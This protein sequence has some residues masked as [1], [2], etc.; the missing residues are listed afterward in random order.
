MRNS[1]HR[2]NQL[3]RSPANGPM[4]RGLW[5]NSVPAIRYLR[6]S[7]VLALCQL[8][9]AGCQPTLPSTSSDLRALRAPFIARGTVGSC[10]NQCW[11]KT[12]PI[13]R[14]D[15]GLDPDATGKYDPGRVA[16]LVRSA[17]S[18]GVSSGGEIRPVSLD[19]VLETVRPGFWTRVLLADANAHLYL[20]LGSI[21]DHG[22]VGYQL[23]HGDSPVLLLSK[24]ELSGAGFQQVWQVREQP[25]P[26]VQVRVGHA[27][28]T[29]DKILHNFGKMRPEQ[30]VETEFNIK[31]TGMVPVIVGKPSPSCGC[32]TTLAESTALAPGEDLHIPARIHTSSSVS[33]HEFIK[34]TLFESNVIA[35]PKEP[36][37]W[38]VGSQA[39]P[40]P[41]GAPRREGKAVSDAGALDGPPS[42]GCWRTSAQIILAQLGIDPNCLDATKPNDVDAIIRAI[43]GECKEPGPTIREVNVAELLP[44][45]GE[46]SNVLGVL[47][48]SDGHLHV[49]IGRIANGSFPPLHHL[50]HGPQDVAL[51]PDAEISS[52]RFTR[53][54]RITRDEKKGVP[55]RIGTG[56]VVVSECDHNFGEITS[57][58]TIS[59]EFAFFNSGKVPIEFEK[60]STS[61][62]CAATSAAKSVVTPGEKTTLTVTV[63]LRNKPSI[64]EYVNQRLRDSASGVL[65]DVSLSLLGSQRTYRAA[66]PELVDFKEVLPGRTYTRSISVEES[67]SDHFEVTG[68]EVGSLPI[69]WSKTESR[70]MRGNRVYRID[71]KLGAGDDLGAGNHSGTIRLL[72]DGKGP[73]I[74]VGILLSVA[75]WFSVSPG[76][77]A[78]GAA[79]VGEAQRRTVRLRSADGQPVQIELVYV[80]PEALVRV[81]SS[82]GSVDLHVS[83]TLLKV[84]LWADRI[85]AIARSG[86]H[87]SKVEIRCVGLGTKS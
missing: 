27:V 38:L 31:N 4:N 78:V 17:Q 55:L 47:A 46:T 64:H 18:E 9:S 63:A 28:L 85:L 7:A 30:D 6:L 76:T 48:A 20:L 12:V 45:P 57:Q 13:L 34:L 83:V 2:V 70:N 73:E 26:V 44:A 53:A 51:V 11:D 81:E 19:S 1:N 65:R 42:D 25:R 35:L 32:T 14:A 50:V 59:H 15:L 74:P 86:R 77:V 72:T 68:V 56:T 29:I 87:E 3:V 62:S 60:A 52:T 54:W 8:T 23:I 16:D 21:E 43:A 79:Q 58:G 84:G 61:C 71:L 49:L 33:L 82:A 66:S 24:A 37:L 41:T 10:P 75:P 36:I 69:T 5:A 22:Q 67:D 80:P 40:A 39:S